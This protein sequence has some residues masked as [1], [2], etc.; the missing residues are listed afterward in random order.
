MQ[1]SQKQIQHL[2]WRTGFGISYSAC[3]ERV[4]WERVRLYDEIWKSA[5]AYA[6]LNT[7]DID[8]WLAKPLSQDLPKEKREQ[9]WG[10]R[11]DTVKRLNRAWFNQMLKP[12]ADLREKM[13]LFWHDH[14]A[15]A[16]T[17]PYLAQ[18]L[19]NTI[20]ENS[21]GN[22]RTL[23]LSVSKHPAMIGYLNN[24]QNRKANPNENFGRELLELFTIG[25]GNYTETDVKEAARAFTGW[26]FRLTEDWEFYFNEEEHD[27]EI[28]VFMNES[29]PFGG[30]D[31]ID[32]L[33]A[34]KETAEFVAQKVYRYLVKE[35]I[36]ERHVSEISSKFY[37]SGYEIKALLDAI[38]RSDW[39][40]NDEA[41]GA[42]MKT[43]HEYLI[44]LTRVLN[45]QYPKQYPINYIQELLGQELFYPPNVGGWPKGMEAIN[46]FTL[47][48]RMK[49][50]E[51]MLEGAEIG[52]RTEFL[53][54]DDYLHI[55]H[56][57]TGTTDVTALYERFEG[58][59]ERATNQELANHLL[60]P[61]AKGISLE[62]GAWWSSRETAFIDNLK[63]LLQSPEYQLC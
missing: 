3:Q 52:K 56:R 18:S 1:L 24:Q 34:R 62:P 33:L 35:E 61:G 23:L 59:D 32:I 58:K 46:N 31:I 44:G 49:L 29:G 48:F 55:Y 43:P 63:L 39:F 37:D 22:F 13:S 21:L 42:K 2:Y 53:A 57:V 15:C 36:D 17:N 51:M 50:P 40:Y 16:E 38:F 14:F 60:Q 12:Q 25:K 27:E 47:L 8:S 6:P 26:Q 20:R 7:I 30:E 11:R 5:E 28:K 10:D 4:G 54:T 41:I 9:Y 19:V 45:V